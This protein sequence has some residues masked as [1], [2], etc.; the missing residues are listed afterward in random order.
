MKR[1]TIQPRK[2]YMQKKSS[3]TQENQGLRYEGKDEQRK[4]LVKIAADHIAYIAEQIER[5]KNEKEVK[6]L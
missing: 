3:L 2:V 5:A 6:E 4:Y 1:P